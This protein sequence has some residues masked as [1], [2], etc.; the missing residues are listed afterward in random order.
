M[1]ESKEARLAVHSQLLIYA[2][3][4]KG[5]TYSDVPYEQFCIS[6]TGEIKNYLVAKV[7]L[8]EYRW[9][10]EHLDFKQAAECLEA[11]NQFFNSLPKIHQYEINS[12]KMFVEIM[13]EHDMDIIDKLYS[14]DVKRYVAETQN[15]LTRN[16][17]L[18]AYEAGVKNDL[19]VAHKHY[20]QIKNSVKTYPIKGEADFL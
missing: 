19:R 3:L 13:C 8:L 15:V 20:M 2:F 11:T 18:M 12:E 1:L 14:A 6:Q 9:H 5:G 17:I 4:T 7:K 10:L 16:R